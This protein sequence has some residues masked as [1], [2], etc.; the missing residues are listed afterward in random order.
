MALFVA[1]I[2]APFLF[3]VALIFST[4][5]GDVL[6]GKALVPRGASSPQRQDVLLEFRTHSVFGSRN[7]GG[8]I[9][10]QKAFFPKLSEYNLPHLIR[11]V[12]PVR[13]TWNGGHLDS[14]QPR[15]A[16]K[17]YLF[18]DR[19]CLKQVIPHLVAVAGASTAFRHCSSIEV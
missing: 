17:S 15:V 10:W 19:H 6:N 3:S 16:V 1:L 9:C 5:M 14:G 8:V 18:G 4:N 11:G 7:R 13:P 12:G 2:L